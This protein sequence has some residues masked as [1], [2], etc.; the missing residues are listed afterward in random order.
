M[1]LLIKYIKS[2]LWRVEKRLSYIEDAQ[3]LNVKWKRAHGQLFDR[4]DSPNATCF[5]FCAV[6]RGVVNGTHQNIPACAH[7]RQN[8]RTATCL[9]LPFQ[10]SANIMDLDFKIFDSE[11]LIVDVEKRPALYK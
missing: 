10:A 8:Y 5:I 4:S 6:R 11:R 9:C 7:E 3:C 2:L 1:C